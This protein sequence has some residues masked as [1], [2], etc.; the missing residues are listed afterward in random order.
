[1]SKHNPSET[2]EDVEQSDKFPITR[3]TA[4]A[5][6]TAAAGITGIGVG[7]AKGSRGRGPPDDSP[8]RGPPGSDPSEGAL[9]RQTLSF[10]GSHRATAYPDSTKIISSSGKTH[11]TW[12]DYTDDEGHIVQAQSLQ[13]DSGTWSEVNTI[14]SAADDHGCPTLTIDSSGHLHVVYGPHHGPMKYKKS[15]SP[16]DVSEWEEEVQFGDNLTYPSLVCGSDDTLYLIARKSTDSWGDW[17]LAFFSK[18]SGEGWS[19]H[20]P[21]FEEQQSGYHRMRHCLAINP[22]TNRLHITTE[23]GAI[24]E[25]AEA[26]YVYSDDGGAT[27][28]GEGRTPFSR[29]GWKEEAM[30]IS[31]EENGNWLV[32]GNITINNS[33]VPYVISSP[34][35]RDARVARL[36]YLDDDDD[37][38]TVQTE[39]AQY[40]PN[41]YREE[42]DFSYFAGVSFTDFGEAYIAASV[43]PKP[44]FGADLAQEVVLFQSDDGGDT[45]TGHAVSAET[46]ERSRWYPSIERRTGHNSIPHPPAVMYTDGGDTQF[47]GWEEGDQ[48]VRWIRWPVC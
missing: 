37:A 3:R 18:D 30:K 10:N 16:N 27:W 4:L 15:A 14:G 1:M 34:R 29:P 40:L 2:K 13:H 45:F 25:N 8:G 35:D 26:Y 42:W 38:W 22:E 41:Q 5:L 47:D 17:K 20:T 32:G 48:A 21:I 46:P 28:R 31:Q 7:S 33:G 36:M 23:L 6:T 12:L 9:G 39:L 43:G 19:E 11:Q 44:R 24:G